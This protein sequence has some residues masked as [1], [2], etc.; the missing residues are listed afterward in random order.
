MACSDK[1]TMSDFI[2]VVAGLVFMAL[3]VAVIAMTV[4]IISLNSGPCRDGVPGDSGRCPHD[5]AALAIESG[6]AVCRCQVPR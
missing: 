1:C 5:D 2:D 6:V 4:W 3:G